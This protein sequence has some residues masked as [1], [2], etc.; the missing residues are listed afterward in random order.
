MAKTY[1]GQGNAGGHAPQASAPSSGP[2]KVLIYKGPTLGNEWDYAGAVNGTTTFFVVEDGP[3]L[4]RY[5]SA[6]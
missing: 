3:T 5:R 2:V 4:G 6:S 1:Y